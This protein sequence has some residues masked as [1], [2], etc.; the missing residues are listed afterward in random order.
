MI[1]IFLAPASKQSGSGRAYNYLQDTVVSPVT[2]SEY[3]E[4]IPRDLPEELSIWGAVD[5]NRDEWNQV[6]KGDFL[7]FYVGNERYRYAAK[8]V[9]TE[10][11]A[12]LADSLWPDYHTTSTGGADPNEPWSLIIY[13]HP[14]FE[15]DIPGREIHRAADHEINYPMRFM[16]LNDQGTS[17][18]ESL[19]GSIEEYFEERSAENSADQTAGQGE[20]PDPSENDDEDPS[21]TLDTDEA[22][23]DI[24]RPKR[25]DVQ[26][27]L[28]IRN[29]TTTKRLKHLYDHECQV[30]GKQRAQRGGDPYAEAHYIHPLDDSPPGPDDEENILVLYPNHH[31][32]FDYG[33]I[34]IDPETLQIS[35]EYDDTVGRR[36]TSTTNTV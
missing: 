25:T 34:K 2:R 18:L 10:T 8:V 23:S 33:Q 30:C 9:D 1:D 27:S 36:F 32:D 3:D 22:S 26:V 5:G 24:R 15:V 16:P 17:S 19:F 31:A 13:M 12:A 20:N 14:A 6:D 11:N 29:T 4:L 28:I 21:S 7:L 35:H